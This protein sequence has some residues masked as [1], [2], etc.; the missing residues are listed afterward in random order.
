MVERPDGTVNWIEGAAESLG[1]SENYDEGHQ[2]KAHLAA[3][4]AIAKALIAIAGVMSRAEGKPKT[5]P[6]VW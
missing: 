5:K 4:Q 3:S 2:G 1:E 6:R